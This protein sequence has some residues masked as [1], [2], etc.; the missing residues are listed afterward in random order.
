MKYDEEEPS[1]IVLDLKEPIH[2]IM[3]IQAIINEDNSFDIELRAGTKDDFKHYRYN[4]KDRNI[5]I[6]NFKK[7]F[8]RENLDYSTWADVTTEFLEP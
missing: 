8:H 1:F 4:L 2:N 6:E 3:Y 7:L 5:I